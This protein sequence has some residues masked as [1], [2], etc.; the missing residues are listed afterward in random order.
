MHICLYRSHEKM[1][2][3]KTK[4]KK[5]QLKRKIR[6]DC[7]ELENNEKVKKVKMID[8]KEDVEKKVTEISKKKS[9]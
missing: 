2:R 4:E 6:K 1:V 3:K 7:R 5:K 8:T 9:I